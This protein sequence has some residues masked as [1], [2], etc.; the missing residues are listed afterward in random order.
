[1][2]SKQYATSLHSYRYL[3]LAALCF[4]VFPFISFAAG[5][6][7][8]NAQLQRVEKLIGKL[9][10]QME[11]TRSRY[12]ILQNELKASEKHIGLLAEHMEQLMQQRAGKQQNHQALRIEYQ[13]QQDKLKEQQQNLGKQIRAAY[14]MGRRDYLKILLNQE[15]PETVGRTLTYYDY[16]NR[17]RAQNIEN[18]HAGLEHLQII[19]TQIELEKQAID[20]LLEKEEQQKQQLEHSIQERAA[21]LKQLVGSLHGQSK[22]IEQLEQDKLHLQEL[23]VSLQDAFGDVLQTEGLLSFQRLKGSFHYPVSGKIV[24]HF[25]EPRSGGLTWQGLLL[26]AKEGEKIQSI[27]AGRVVFSD[28]LRNF[29]QLLI[30]DHGGGYMSLYGHNRSLYKKTG[31]QV[32]SGEV[33]ATAGNSGGRGRPALYFE[34]RRQGEALDPLAW[35]RGR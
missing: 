23:L 13:R 29:G 2:R 27:A 31:E 17:V 19:E 16:F 1:M 34:I 7:Q 18:I 25:G 24:K 22:Q 9:Q 33:I 10:A 28:W 12:G 6:E 35:M 32:K 5:F 21:I 30:I 26:A 4:L 14:I 8:A 11:D 3:W 15:K 20:N